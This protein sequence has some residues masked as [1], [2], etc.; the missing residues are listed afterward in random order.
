MLSK[1]ATLRVSCL[2]L[3]NLFIPASLRATTLFEPA[4]AYLT[5]GTGAAG[6]RAMVVVDVNGDGKPDLVVANVCT[7]VNNCDGNISVLL[8]N[9]DGTF[10]SAK[11]TDAG[12]AG[13]SIAVADLNGDGKPDL[14]VSSGESCSPNPCGPLVNVLFGNGDGTFREGTKYDAGQELISLVLA[15]V[16]QDGK[17]DIVVATGP[18]STP[19]NAVGVLLGNGDG[20]FQPVQNYDSGALGNYLTSLAVA[21]V[22]GDGKLDLVVAIYSGNVGV[23][24]GNGDGTFQP[25]QTYNSGSTGSSSIAIADVNGDGKPD[26][27]VTNYYVNNG[28]TTSP[29][30]VLLGNGDGTFQ[31]V[32][33]FCTG[34]LGAQSIA[35]ADVNGDGN[36]DLLVAH[37]CP[38]YCYN[39]VLSVMLGNGDG[40][41]KAAQRYSSGGYDTFS[42]VVADVNGDD[43]PDVIV[44]NACVSYGS[45]FNNTCRTNNDCLTG[46]VAVLL[47]TSGVKTTTTLSSSLNPS[48]YGKAVTLT[49]TVTSV[50]QSTPTGTVTFSNGT[51]GLGAAT[52]SGGTAMLTRSW[53]PAGVRSMT[54]TYNGDPSSAKSTSASLS[55]T[56]KKAPTTTTIVSS[57][58]PSIQGQSVTFT[59]KVTS[60]VGVTGTVTF[61]ANGS[62]LGT[63]TLSSG[64]ASFTTS[65]LSKGSNQKIT[66]KYNGTSN[67][68]GSGASLLQTVN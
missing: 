56:I 57:L 43:K 11:A 5:A 68:L 33:N 53:L 46:N 28:C 40:T 47:G 39:S 37:N 7:N 66:A 18:L 12:F 38:N 59:A 35:V 19:S 34:A 2:A 62:T 32:Q 67:V 63:V 31:S 22:N 48:V 6:T 29:V 52:L 55:Q 17:L 50:G 8:G 64:K 42:I 25:V 24:L 61:T 26:V 3:A 30:G 4:Q 10:Q 13:G 21:D 15:D 60:T 27:L 9:G 20:T 45:C 23:L 36:L 16:N 58:N 51:I 44:A 65:A 54:A 49:A 14:V 41:F 1:T